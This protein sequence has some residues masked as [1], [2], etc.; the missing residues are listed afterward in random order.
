MNATMRF[1]VWGTIPL[2]QIIGGV[3]A[4]AVSIPAA[5]WIGGLGELLAVVPLLVTPVR[6]LRD[7]PEPVDAPTPTGSEVETL[8]EVDP[9]A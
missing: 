3:I 5:L 2:G 4:T 8:A 1:I 7:M 6:S 9:T